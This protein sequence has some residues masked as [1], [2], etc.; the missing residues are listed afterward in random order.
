MTWTRE[1]PTKPGAYWW[2]ITP[3]AKPVLIDVQ[4]R[5]LW[6]RSWD[7]TAKGVLHARLTGTDN[8]ELIGEGGEWHPCEPPPSV[9]GITLHGER[10]PE[11][12]TE[13]GDYYVEAPEG[14]GVIRLGDGLL[15]RHPFLS[16]DDDWYGPLEVRP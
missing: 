10:L 12:P 6:T 9:D 1:T 16:N 3:L 11:G 5:P 14:E 13:P 8:W 4:R 7:K 2:R 15:S